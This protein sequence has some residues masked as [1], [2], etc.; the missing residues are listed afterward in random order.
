MLSKATINKLVSILKLDSATFE[1][2]LTDEKE[3]DITIDDK[4]QILDEASL[5]SRDRNKYN[6]GKTAGQEMLIKE[7]KRKHA[8]EVDGDDPDKVVE[9]IVS[10]TKKEV[11]GNPDARVADLE[12][13]INQWKQKYSDLEGS[14][15]RAQQ[16][17]AEAALDRELL[18]S[19]PKSR[20]SKF[21]DDEYLTLVKKSLKIEDKDGKRIIYKDGKPLQSD[22]DFEPIPLKDAIEGYFGERKWTEAEGGAGG[23]GGG[24]GPGAGGGNSNPGGGKPKFSKLSEVNAHLAGEGID[25]KGEKGSAF[26]QAVIK[27][28]P[29]LDFQN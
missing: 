8:I 24:R 13:K 15:T 12:G 16:E 17:K 25:P 21:T 1:A 14:Y 27:E 7:I 29:T 19:F 6:E 11:G 10:K 9:A 23:A 22:K 26:I 5:A 3:V 2:A 28:N 18:S 4:L 20:D